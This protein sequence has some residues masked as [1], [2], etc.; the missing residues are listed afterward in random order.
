N[1]ITNTIIVVISLNHSVWVA[2]CSL[3]FLVVIHKLEYFVNARLVAG[4][5]NAAAWELL[6]AMLLMER[7]F[8]IP[9][10]VVAPIVY[11]YVKG[12]LSAHGLV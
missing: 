2:M 5:I 9:G 7:L 10:L 3:V 1:L 12:E 11:A 6:I 4:R 8:G